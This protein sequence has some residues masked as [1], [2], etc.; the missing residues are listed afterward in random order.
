MIQQ[1]VLSGL[2]LDSYEPIPPNVF[3]SVTQFEDATA[4]LKQ[5][6]D[7]LTIS[8]P[9]TESEANVK[10]DID[11]EIFEHPTLGGLHAGFWH[12]IEGLGALLIDQLKAAKNIALEGHSEGAARAG[13]F[14]LWCWLNDINISQLSVYECPRFGFAQSADILQEMVDAGMHAVSTVNGLDPVPH[15]PIE[16]YVVPIKN[17]LEIHVEPGGWLAD[18]DPVAWHDMKL[19]HYGLV[20]LEAA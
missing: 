20:T 6:D 9:G 3:G 12:P 5:I 15:I 2:V 1:S 17:I 7:T 4:C 19:I 18:A 13:L 8:F 16:P 11:I 14:A 10:T